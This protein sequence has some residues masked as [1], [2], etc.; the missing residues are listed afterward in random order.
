MWVTFFLIFF[1]SIVAVEQK[2]VVTSSWWQIY[3]LIHRILE[4]SLFVVVGGPGKAA[5]IYYIEYYF[6]QPNFATNH[7]FLLSELFCC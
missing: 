5:N 7:V 4:I 1:V 3:L 2:L 6:L